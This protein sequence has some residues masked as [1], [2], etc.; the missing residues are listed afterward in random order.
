MN[1]PSLENKKLKILFIAS[2][3]FP[4]AK[5]G[6]LGDVVGS[7]SAA[8][9]SRGHDVRVVLP[10]YS[11][12][13]LNAIGAKVRLEPMGVWMG[14]IEEWCS[15]YESVSSARV[16]VYFI[17]HKTYFDREGLYHDGAMRD[18]GDNPRRFGFLCRAALQ[19]CRDL[20]FAPDVV[21]VND[22]QT[23]LATAYLKVWHWNDPLLRNTASLLTIHNAAY[24]GVYPKS[25]YDY[26]GL[27]WHNFN[28]DVFETHDQI[29]ILKGGISFAD[30]IVAVSPTFAREIKQP[31]G[32]F[33]LAPY[34]SRRE[35]DL[36]GI[37]NGIDYSIWDP[38]KDP[39]IPAHYSVDALKGKK[40]CKK[41]LQERFQLAIDDNIPVIGAIG[42]FVEQKGFGL[43]TQIIERV[44]NEMRPEGVQFVVLGEGARDLEDYFYHLPGR[45]AG[46]AGSFIGFDDE[47]AHLIN[48]G[49]DFFLMP[50]QWEPCGLNQLYAQRYGTLPIVRAV[51][52]LDDTVE[53]Y[54]ESTGA[55]TGFKFHDFTAHALYYTIGWAVSTWYDRPL[56]INKMIGAAMGQDFSWDTSAARY[57]SAYAKAMANKK[58]HDDKQK[59]YYK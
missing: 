29:N 51:G 47:R 23:A 7:L 25:H 53:N 57:E 3:M 49:C 6:G 30:C 43:I 16:P 54:D 2:E 17:E 34:L 32:G 14:N 48:A 24:Q 38:G 27:G 10:R 40:R 37:V 39:K 19:V 59:R 15:V 28:G 41:K 55:G 26:L 44:L 45:F 42:R 12:I 22:W 4:F 21:H 56:H 20:S 31:S 33:G 18:Y 8:L 11:G 50:S 13:D 58:T 46:H 5:V 52:G 36:V 1:S 9:A 35:D